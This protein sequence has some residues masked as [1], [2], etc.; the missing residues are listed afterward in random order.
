M[1]YEL[2]NFIEKK[3]DSNLEQLFDKKEKR[4]LELKK[5]REKCVTF[6]V[7]FKAIITKLVRVKYLFELVKDY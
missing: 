3:L 2:L 6:P 4:D 7:F 5:I 1:E